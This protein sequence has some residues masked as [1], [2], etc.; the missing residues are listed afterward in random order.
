[1]GTTITLPEVKRIEQ[2]KAAKWSYDFKFAG[3]IPSTDTI[4]PA[5]VAFTVPTGIS[6]VSA[7]TAISGQTVQAVFDCTSAEDN[8][9]YPVVCKVTT[10]S[11]KIVPRYL[12]LI[13]R[14]D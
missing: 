7:Q 8:K 4:A 9:E 2:R 1:M 14:P 11:G 13:V 10:S 12:I 6:V 5:D 3:D